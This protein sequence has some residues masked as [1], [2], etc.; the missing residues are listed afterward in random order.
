MCAGVFSVAILVMASSACFGA[1][2]QNDAKKPLGQALKKSMLLFPFDVPST[3]APNA[4][5]LSG[6]LTDAAASRLVASNA[7]SVTTYYRAWP[8][9]A[10]LHS[11]QQIGEADVIPPFAEDNR[12][13]VKIA[14]LVE[15]ETVCIG[16]V[17]DYQY[18]ESDRQVS[19]TVS[20]RII[21]AETGQVL[22]NVTLSATSRPGNAKAKEE[23]LNMDA[24]RQA[25]EK[26]MSQ[27]A[28]M[29]TV[30]T[31]IEATKPTVAKKKRGNDWVWG[32]LAIGLGLGIG[33]SGGGSGGGG[34][35]DGP[36]APPR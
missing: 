8:P 15:Y 16:S 27:L 14:K 19:L 20:G 30:P 28:P 10:R 33:L 5:E 4:E 23:D 2:A 18:N 21:V 29:G 7:Y 36:P 13:S 34:G 9:V 11:D 24:G 1:P 22:K 26:L 3:M 12:K 17:D 31:Y 32:L 35:I 25:M 6:L